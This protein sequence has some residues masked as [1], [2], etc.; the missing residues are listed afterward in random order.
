MVEK[1]FTYY[2]A[3]VGKWTGESNYWIRLLSGGGGGG[4]PFAQLPAAVFGF[5]VGG[6]EE[7]REEKLFCSHSYSPGPAGIGQ[8]GRCGQS[9]NGANRWASNVKF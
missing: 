8:F 9:D 4:G 5:L 3:N 7:V 1:H 2:A 6:R